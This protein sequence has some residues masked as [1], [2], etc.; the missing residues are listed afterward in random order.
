MAKKDNYEGHKSESF[1]RA[2]GR[3]D[4]ESGKTK[5]EE[6]NRERNVAPKGGEEHS[7]IPKGNRG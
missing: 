2:H 4:G 5:Q 3:R 6:T 1:N 7:R